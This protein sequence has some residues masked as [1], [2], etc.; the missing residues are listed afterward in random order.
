[1]IAPLP[2]GFPLVTILWMGK[3]RAKWKGIILHK[4]AKITF[5]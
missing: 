1:M 4:K 3:K 2:L 5:V